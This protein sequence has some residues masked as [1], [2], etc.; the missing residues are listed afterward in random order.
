MKNAH[1]SM[2]SLAVLASLLACSASAADEIKALQATIASN[3]VTRTSKGNR[4]YL[5]YYRELCTKEEREAILERNIAA[6]RRWIALAGENGAKPQQAAMPRAELGKVLAIG[7]RWKEAEKELTEALKYDFDKTKTAEARWALAECLWHRKDKDGAKKVVAEMAAMQWPKNAPRV[8]EKARFMHRQWTDPDGDLDTLNLPHSVDC[9][10]FPTP[11]E[12]EYGE[13]KVSL[14]KVEVQFR[15][16]GTTGTDGAKAASPASLARPF[17]PIVRL[18]KRKLTRFGSKFEKGGTKITI[19]ISPDAPVDKPQGY[20]LRVQGLGGLDGL[21]G[22]G[23]LVSIKARDRLG[24][25]W[26]VV[27]FLQCVDRGEPPKPSKPLNHELS[28]PSIRT[29]RIK[30]WPKLERRGVIEGFWYPDFLEFALFHKMSSLVVKMDRPECGFIFSTLEREW[31]RLT[32]KRYHDYGID[33]YW[34]SNELSVSPVLPLSA[35]RTRALHLAWFRCAAMIGAGV[36]FEMDDERFFGFPEEDAKVAGTAANLDA[37]YITGLYR[38]MKEDFPDFKMIFGPPF[39]F[40]PDG[41]LDPSWYPEPR[42]A[43][44]KS[45]G[46]FLDPEIGVYW[47]GPRVKSGGFTPEKIK[48]F[49]DLVGRRQVVYHNGDCK[50]WHGHVPFGADIPNF[51]GSHCPETLDLIAGLYMNMTYY[52]ETCKVGSCMD[53]CWN[54][55]AHNPKVAVR[56]AIEQAEGP[57]VFEIVAAATPSLSYFDKYQYGVPRSELFSEDLND[58]EKRVA[59]AEKAWNDVLAIA[60]NGGRFVDGFNSCGLYWARRLRNMRKSPPEWLIKQR[61]AEMKNTKFAVAEVGYD[62]SKGDQFIPSELMQ[63]GD[64]NPKVGDRSGPGVRGV[65]YVPP[66]EVVAATF[67]CDE[68]PPERPP[69]VFVVG[70]SFHA[71]VVPEIEIEVNGSIVWRGPAFAKPYYFTPLEVTIPVNTLQRSNRLVVRNVSPVSEPFRKPT[72]HYAVIKR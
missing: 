69:K 21:G 1:L 12:A 70:A 60:K 17:D 20:E 61:D 14:A 32:V 49:A 3:S 41:G 66:G 71:G 28:K 9:K 42:D 13:K 53:W 16:N 38:E 59:D 40:G 54:P 35:Q 65:K 68:F 36:C 31:C 58:L 33:A 64:Y 25:L 51:K 39:Y 44:L 72:I 63:G 22:S 10:P 52:G 67:R 11:Q 37:K 55:E 56:R 50:G 8:C 5:A 30:D 6:H 57:G 24:A 46:E 7:G 29:L 26:G 18:L 43:Y 27:S 47:T 2:M 48:W 34:S 4:Y 15:T 62:E 45:L 23:G 19:E